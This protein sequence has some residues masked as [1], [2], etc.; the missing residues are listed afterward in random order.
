MVPAGGGVA[1]PLIAGSDVGAATVGWPAFLPD[2]RHFLF[3]TVGT[4]EN[5][6][7]VGST[8]P[9]FEPVEILATS[10]LVLFAPPR[11]LLYV[12]D[13]TLVAQP[14]DAESRELTGEPVPLA[15]EVGASG[16]G[17]A[18]IS[19]SNN[20]VLVYRAGATAAR[21]LVWVDRSGKELEEIDEPAEYGNSALSPSGDRVVLQIA[22]TGT[23]NGDLWIRDLRRGVNSRFTFDAAHEDH[24]VWSPD[25][26]SVFFASD[27][28][29][30]NGIYKKQASG[31]GAAELIW[32]AGQ[33]LPVPHS[34][35]PDGR[36]LAFHMLTD[37]SSWDIYILELE[38]EDA[39]QAS[40]YIHTPFVEVRPTFS[41]DGK[42]LAYDSV[43][44]GRIEVYARQFEGPGGKW[45]I[46]T[47]GGSQPVWGPDGTEL[48]YVGSDRKL[49]RVEIE[50]GE[51]LQVGLPEPLFDSMFHP[52]I[53][54]N[55]YVSDRGKR[56]LMV[57]TTGRETIFPATVVL[58]W[59]ATLR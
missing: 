6:L 37:E 1:K 45:Q 36:H 40:A 35:S 54:R 42:W 29:G 5:R 59:D 28:D 3:T 56:F 4:G 39:G 53:M 41:P 30:K 49:T 7:F 14:F 44:S 32:E 12:R 22:D 15:E 11:H 25:G 50:T 55:H 58:N 51:S 43:E 27:R 48:Y 31:V 26:R 10:S 13:D 24:P 20:G 2:G 8:E 38:G 19:A 9:G 16:V 57:R 18:H 52:T 47:D 21:R 33:Q 17:L 46:S 34:I 23:G